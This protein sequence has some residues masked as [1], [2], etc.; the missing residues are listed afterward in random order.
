MQQNFAYP[1]NF[2]QKTNFLHFLNRSSHTLWKNCLS[3]VI[4]SPLLRHS[5]LLK[6]HK[7]ALCLRRLRLLC[8]TGKAVNGSIMFKEA[9]VSRKMVLTNL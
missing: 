3:I 7:K 5:A 2:M 4:L 8:I 9:Y 6:K 1:Q